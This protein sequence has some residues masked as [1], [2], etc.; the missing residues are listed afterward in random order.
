M[1]RTRALVLFSLSL[2]LL[3]AST[4]PASA[5]GWGR[6]ILEKMS[7]PG[8][9]SGD[10]GRLTALCVSRDPDQPV[11]PLWVVRQPEETTL[12]CVDVDYSNYQNDDADRRENGL[13]TFNRYQA[14]VMLQAQPFLEA[15]AGIGRAKFSRD[16]F[17]VSRVVVPLRLSFKPLRLPGIARRLEGRRWA[18]VPK[19]EYTG[20]LIPQR[21]KTADFRVQHEF[22]HIFLSGFGVML[23]FSELIAR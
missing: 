23:D 22:D 8:P 15:G 13:I 5:Q 6:G 7:G 1:T 21:V 19:L 18:G 10:D 17:D 4:L 2:T 16:D 12:L 9:F 11:R 3:L 14:V 20:L